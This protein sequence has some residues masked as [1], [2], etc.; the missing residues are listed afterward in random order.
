MPSELTA[1]LRP[2]CYYSTPA[3]P[4]RADDAMPA[5]APAG[6]DD[7][8]LADPDGAERGRGKIFQVIE[9]NTAQ[10]RPKQVLT[11]AQ[12]KHPLNVNAVTAT[13]QFFQEWDGD[14]TKV[15]IIHDGEP[16]TVNLLHV[17]DRRDESE[18]LCWTCQVASAPCNIL[19]LVDSKPAQPTVALQDPS[20]PTLMVLRELRR[21]GFAARKRGIT[22]TPEDPWPSVYDCQRPMHKPYF[23]CVLNWQAISVNVASM[24]SDQPLSYYLLLLR[25]QTPLPCLG[26]KMYRRYLALPAD[27]PLALPEQDDVP[28][29]LEDIVLARRSAAKAKAKARALPAIMDARDAESDS[30]TSNS[31]DTNASSSPYVPCSP[32][33]DEVELAAPNKGRRTILSDGAYLWTITLPKMQLHTNVGYFLVVVR[34]TGAA[35]RKGP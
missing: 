13:L 15:Q 7:A 29:P 9:I 5:A 1:T 10:H 3:A 17:V 34:A 22:H 27:A 26:D 19:E 18:L 33:G 28:L 11:A 20:C 2:S 32:S 24:P 21:I 12:L 16:E 4:A 23:Q 30:S 31:T 25:G 8:E 6:A 35:S 14:A